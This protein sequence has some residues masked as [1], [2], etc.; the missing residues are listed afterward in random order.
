MKKSN[1]VCKVVGVKKL[2]VLL[3]PLKVNL[4]GCGTV[5]L[6]GKGILAQLKRVISDIPIIGNMWLVLQDIYIYI[7]MPFLLQMHSLLE[8]DDFHCNRGDLR[9]G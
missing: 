1:W 7:Y 3:F 2:W 8:R 9:S 4:K 5:V 6:Y